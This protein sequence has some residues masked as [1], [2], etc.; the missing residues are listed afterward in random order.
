MTVRPTPL[1]APASRTERL[2]RLPFTARHRSMLVGSGVGWALDAMDVGLISFLMVA[3]KKEWGLTT[4]DLSVLASIGFVGMAIGAG[5]GGALADRIG[6]RT[7][8]AGTLVVYG[9]ATGLSA[10]APSFLVL[11]A[12]RFVVGLGL[13]AEL[14]VAST[15]VS[16]FAPKRLRGRMVVALESFW[17]L[18][19]LLAA[20]IGF[21]IVPHDNGWRWA[22]ALGLV[23]ALYAIHVRRGLPESVRF[24][25]KAGRDDDAE[26]IVRSFEAAAGPA[27]RSDGAHLDDGDLAGGGEPAQP[28]GLGLRDTF[29]TR[30]PRLGLRPGLGVAMLFLE[31]A[32]REPRLGL[33]LA[34]GPGLLLG[35]V[36]G[37]RG[38][39]L[40]ADPRRPRAP[41]RVPRPTDAFAEGRGRV[42]TERLAERHDDL[43]LVV[44]PV[45]DEGIEA[46]RA[47]H[48]RAGAPGLEEREHRQGEGG[49][50]AGSGL[51]DAEDILA[52]DHMGDRLFLDRRGLCVTGVLDGLDEGVVE[53]VGHH[54]ILRIAK[55][56]PVEGDVRGGVRDLVGDGGGVGAEIRD[57]GCRFVSINPQR[58]A[59]DQYLDADWVRIIPNTDIALFLGMAHHVLEAGLD[60]KGMPDDINDVVEG[61]RFYLGLTARF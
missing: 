35:A 53:R 23:P 9:L 10:L 21:T 7:V 61:R 43:D 12:L 27:Q 33:D 2:D 26:R 44:H 28:R 5:V 55:L 47:R 42:G 24:L 34:G 20:V 8:F 11:C 13:G 46:Q 18:G 29:G 17:A 22:M 56:G 49:G 14:P 4:G 36:L 54:R 37:G 38:R 45:S 59:S 39:E 32:Q 58:T 48:P 40:L 1:S 31:P 51:G 41:Q 52:C 57:A 60:E 15:L 16:E 25:E 19:W 50:L 30:R 3:V 6:R